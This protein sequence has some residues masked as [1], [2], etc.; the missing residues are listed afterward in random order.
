MVGEEE[1]EEEVKR[2]NQKEQVVEVEEEAE[3]VEQEVVVEGEGE[4]GEEERKAEG[5]LGLEALAEGRR[6]GRLLEA[7]RAKVEE[8]LL[9]WEDLASRVPAEGAQGGRALGDQALVDKVPAPTAKAL[10]QKAAAAR[11]LQLLRRNLLRLFWLP[12]SETPTLP[13]SV[14]F[15]PAAVGPQVY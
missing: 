10:L 12:H 11:A 1:E 7:R 8:E 6:K 15:L 3:V 5:I 4:G 2:A 9:G 14:L 13:L